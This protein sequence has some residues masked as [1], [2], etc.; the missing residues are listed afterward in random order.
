MVHNIFQE[1]KEKVDSDIDRLK[2]LLPVGISPAG[3]ERYRWRV[4]FLKSGEI[5]ERDV[6]ARSPDQAFQDLQKYLDYRRTHGL[7]SI[8]DL[9]TVELR[10]TTTGEYPF[11]ASKRVLIQGQ[12]F[13]IGYLIAE[14]LGYQI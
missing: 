4:S 6:V 8:S 9:V 3:A 13:P 10:N 1:I 2:R 11:V 14:Y 7:S 12:Q 5:A